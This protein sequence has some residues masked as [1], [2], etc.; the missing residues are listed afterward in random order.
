MVMNVILDTEQ[1]PR[2]QI[3]LDA[4]SARNFAISMVGRF[5]AE[6]ASHGFQTVAVPQPDMMRGAIPRIVLV[7]AANVRLV[8][9]PR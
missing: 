1:V 8:V 2:V 3:G 9:G 4:P 5:E 7:E 6:P